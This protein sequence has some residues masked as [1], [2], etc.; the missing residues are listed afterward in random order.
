M[1]VLEN[2]KKSL[3]FKNYSERT[4]E[5]YSCYLEKFI[6][7]QNIKDPYQVATKQIE[8]Y[9]LNRNY[10]STSQQNQIIGSLKLFAKYILRKKDIHLSKIERPRK[11]KKLPKIT[12]AEQLAKKINA[13]PNLKH[14]A[15]LALGLS[16]G[17][18]ISEVVNLKWEHLDSKEKTLS[19]INGKGGKDR[20][21]RLT[22]GMIQI[23]KSYYLEYRSKEYVFNGQKKLK[24]S[25]SSIQNIFKKY[26]SKNESFHFLR[27]SYGTFAVDSGTPLPVLQKTMGHN[28]SKTTEIYLHLS[29]K[30]LNQIKTAI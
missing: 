9:L 16:C 7:E 1:K 19:V 26:I 15:I 6:K 12:D 4:I 30:S 25:T 24:Y 27:H 13:V 5:V 3:R 14:K 10:S 8:R 28:S 11:Q 17:L 23:L 29:N 21:V 18:R 2:F 22:D 20:N